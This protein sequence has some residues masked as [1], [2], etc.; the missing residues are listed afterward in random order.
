[1]AVG[2]GAVEVVNTTVK[3]CD[4]I[5]WPYTGLFLG[6]L[7]L[8]LRVTVTQCQEC[9]YLSGMMNYQKYNLIREKF[10]CRIARI[11]TNLGKFYV[12]DT[13]HG[14]N[15]TFPMKVYR[16]V[17]PC[18]LGLKRKEQT[19]QASALG[20]FI[21]IL[22]QFSSYMGRLSSLWVWMIMVPFQHFASRELP[23]FL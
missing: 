13:L 4:P 21:L 12:T 17:S 15:K 1:M 18:D 2:A 20:L 14:G 11:L 19:H 7:Y 3:Y 6:I 10:P 8:Q 22:I 23:L 16:I 9:Y 5:L